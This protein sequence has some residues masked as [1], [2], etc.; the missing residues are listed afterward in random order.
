MTDYDISLVSPYVVNGKDD[1]HIVGGK[2]DAH[3]NNKPQAVVRDNNL[4]DIIGG[5][6]NEELDN[7]AKNVFENT[8]ECAI[9]SKQS[10]VCSP[11]EIISKMKSFA[12]KS[13]IDVKSNKDAVDAVKK[14]TKCSSESCAVSNKEFMDFAKITNAKEF[15]DK[16][17]KPEGPS[18]DFGLLSNFNIDEVLEQLAEKYEPR[19]YHIPFQMRDFKK[20]GSE[21]ATVDIPDV[22]NSG[23]GCF[24]VVL[25]TDWSSG[26]GIHWFCLYGEN[27]KDHVILEYF[28]SS[29]NQP[30]PEVQAWLRKT[31]HYV[32]KKLN[33]PVKV[34]YHT[35]VQF[36]D[37]DHSCGV[38]CLCYIWL[39]LE[40]LP[41]D[42]FSK[43]NINDSRMHDMRKV[44]FRH[45]N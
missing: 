33:K 27:K 40:N 32:E 31:Q 25:N 4:L 1:G 22:F 44:L 12:K 13:G 23:A 17:F 9:N 39:R 19:F 10:D 15:M 24:G 45:E 36:Q 20:V 3:D 18:H 41:L 35:G 8:S 37:D 30:L 28:N 2:S 6:D 38:Y 11:P 14:I 21:L 29:G 43:K 5:N 42:W 7:K 26:R 34:H 16:F